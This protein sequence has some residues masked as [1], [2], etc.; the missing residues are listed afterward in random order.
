VAVATPTFE[1]IPRYAAMSG[2]AVRETPWPD[3]STY[4]LGQVLDSIDPDV[5]ALAL[6]TPNNP[7]GG[8]VT[9]AQAAAVTAR[10]G[11]PVLLDLAYTEF[12]ED[13]LTDLALS[14]PGV[15]AVRTFSK[16]WGL[17]GA[18]VGYAVGDRALIAAM[19]ARGGPYS[20]GAAGLALAA[21]VL[22]LAPAVLA[23]RVGQVVRLRAALARLVHE[24]GFRA[25]ES[26]GNFVLAR[27]ADA[28]EVWTRL[29]AA[30]VL[31]RRWT[32]RPGLADALRITCPANDQQMRTLDEALRHAAGEAAR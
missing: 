19:R 23:E 30:G 3:G 27:R 22:D 10:A 11:V 21:A 15:V 14:C 4:P 6:V 17:A 31:V 16:A 9:R 28:G 12:A 24:L 18:R 8:V 2:G 13:D 29:R 5:A 20:V 26:Q 7:T 32:D 1:M 25:A